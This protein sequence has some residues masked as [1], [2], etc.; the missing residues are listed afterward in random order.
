MRVSFEKC[1]GDNQCAFDVRLKALPIIIKVGV[2][3]QGVLVQIPSIRDEDINAAELLNNLGK[4]EF[5]SPAIA[6]PPN[7]KL[8]SFLVPR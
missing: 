8:Q 5:N 3:N 6:P 7:L 1:F 2:S 4:H